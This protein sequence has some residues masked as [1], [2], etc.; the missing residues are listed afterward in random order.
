MSECANCRLKVLIAS[1][2]QW[3][4][5]RGLH[6]TTDLR[7]QLVK[8]IEEL[9]EI[10]AG[11]ARNDHTRIVDGVGD[12]LVVLL[13][14]GAVH[15]KQLAGITASE[16]ITECLSFAVAEIQNRSGHLKDGIFIKEGE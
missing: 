16:Y 3:G 14:F 6:N 12:L 5:A 13:Q 11:V 2:L 10:A 1:A 7:P 15:S 4:E 8:L 9:G